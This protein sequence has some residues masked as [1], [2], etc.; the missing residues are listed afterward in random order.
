[1]KKSHKKIDSA[2]EQ[3]DK[4]YLNSFEIFLAFLEPIEIFSNNNNKS[5]LKFPEDSEIGKSKFGNWMLYIKTLYNIILIFCETN[6]IFN[7][8]K[9][10]GINS[11]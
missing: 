10:N 3:I 1:M 9:R 7:Y 2:I 5:H 11:N 8:N 6:F 4:V